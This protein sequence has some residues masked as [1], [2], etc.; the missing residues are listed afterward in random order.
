MA[1]FPF[2]AI[3]TPKDPLYGVCMAMSEIAAIKLKLIDN[4]YI[5]ISWRILDLH[6]DPSTSGHF[7]HPYCSGGSDQP[8]SGR[9]YWVFACTAHSFA[10]TALLASLTCFAALIHSL[11]RSLTHSQARGKV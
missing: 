8:S 7:S 10:C 2:L 9:E 6:M 1:I 3:L 4:A 11:A 5:I